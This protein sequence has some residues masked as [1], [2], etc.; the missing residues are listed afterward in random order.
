MFSSELKFNHKH[1]ATYIIVIITTIV[2]LAQVI[3]FG[4]QVAQGQNLLNAGA[5]WSWSIIQNPMELW[6]LV[7]PIF[8][9]L[10]WSHFLFNMFTLFFIGRMIEE[11]F[12]SIRFAAI[13]LLSGIFANAATFFLST[14][15]L[16]AG[17]STSIFGIFGAIAMLGFF[18]GDPRLKEIG[19]GFV[20]LIVI[21]LAFNFFQSGINVVG[22]IGGVIGG[23]LL[24]AMF[25]PRLYAKWIPK[26]I[27]ILSIL[28]FC[29][30]LL[31]FILLPFGQ[32]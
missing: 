11:I 5:L 9:H 2:W 20:V 30:L 26:H 29:V 32:R 14:N 25:P 23:G 21:N 16:S 13:Y 3:S 22:H 7:S 1:L 6:R 15:A 28:T 19:K 12:G 24:A 8:L 27:R 17:A 10:S 18:T 4:S 31:V